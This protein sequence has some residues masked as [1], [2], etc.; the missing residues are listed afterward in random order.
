ML[1]QSEVIRIFYGRRSSKN[2]TQHVRLKAIPLPPLLVHVS[3]ATMTDELTAP[4]Q[5]TNVAR[6]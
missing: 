3:H 1:V 4:D 6:P 2:G 5:A